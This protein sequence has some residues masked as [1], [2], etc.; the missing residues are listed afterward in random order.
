MRSVFSPLPKPQIF[1][2]NFP[3]KIANIGYLGKTDGPF[4]RHHGFYFC[5]SLSKLHGVW[6]DRN[7]ILS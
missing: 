6:K 4:H 3:I 5:L 1:S 7:Q 2:S